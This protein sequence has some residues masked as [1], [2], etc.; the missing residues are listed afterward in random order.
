MDPYL[1]DFPACVFTPELPHVNSASVFIT[2]LKNEE[3][4]TEASALHFSFQMSEGS[5]AFFS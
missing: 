2:L 3:Q 1:M 5:T 4:T